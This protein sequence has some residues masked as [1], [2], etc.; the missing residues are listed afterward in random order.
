VTLTLSEGQRRFPVEARRIAAFL[1]ASFGVG[2]MLGPVLGGWIA[3]WQAGFELPLI[4][5]TGC[6]F[7]GGLCVALDGGFTALPER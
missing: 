2:Q 4:L 5:A 6:V 7:L 3:D 1:T